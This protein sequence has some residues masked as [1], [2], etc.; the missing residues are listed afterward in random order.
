M[1]STVKGYKLILVMPDTMS[2][3]RRNFCGNW[4]CK[5]F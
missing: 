5:S 4:S 2:I 1:V 3:E